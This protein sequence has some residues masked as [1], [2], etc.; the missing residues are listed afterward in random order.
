MKQKKKKIILIAEDDLFLS[1]MIEDHLKG[2]GFT[3]DLAKDG[4]TALNKIKENDYALV[5]L[6]LIMPKRNGF[7]VLKE[8]KD[9][10]IKTTPIIIFSNLSQAE[11]EEEA[12]QLG[13]RA[14]YASHN[15][16]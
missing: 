11:D 15:K 3:V 14:Y 9:A 13:A 1:K 6:D 7:E 16:P 4:E 8:L 2:E 5:L 12:L 10:K